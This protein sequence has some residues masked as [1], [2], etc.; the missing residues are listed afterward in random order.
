MLPAR[1]LGGNGQSKNSERLARPLD[2]LF[3]RFEFHSNHRL[4]I[5]VKVQPTACLTLIA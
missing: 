5:K 3:A 1:D 2:V 4:A